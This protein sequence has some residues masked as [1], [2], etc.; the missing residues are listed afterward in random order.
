MLPPRPEYIRRNTRSWSP[1]RIICFDAEGVTQR[2]PEGELDTYR[3]AVVSFDVRGKG[4]TAART[5]WGSF[6]AP[7]AS[8]RDLW[9]W[10]STRCHVGRAT[11]AFAHGTHYDYSVTGAERWLPELG[12][13]RI[14]WSDTYGARWVRWR[15]GKRALLIVDTGNYLKGWQIKDLG[16]LVGLVK[17]GMPRAQA[18]RAAWERYCRRDVEI[19]REVVLRLLEWWDEQDLG[20][21]GF[22]AP[23][24]AK[25]A[26]RHRFMAE[27]SIKCGLP[28]FRALEREAL[29]GGRREIYRKGRLVSAAWADLDYVSH[30]MVTAWETP[31][32]VEPGAVYA[33]ADVADG[34]LERLPPNLGVIARVEVDMRE[35]AVPYRHPRLGICYP[36]GRFVT[37]L[38]QP[39]LE[40]VAAHGR[41][42]RWLEVA[43]YGLAPALESWAEWV[44]AGLEGT[45]RNQLARILLKDWTRSLIG[46]FGQRKPDPQPEVP[47][48][49]P[50]V[51]PEL[52]VTE[53]MVSHDLPWT[54]SPPPDPLRGEDSMNTAPAITAWVHSAARATLWRAMCAVGRDTIAS[55]DTDGMLV[56]VEERNVEAIA[57]LAP[58]VDATKPSPR[59]ALP[60][61][62]RARLRPT[63]KER[64]RAS[65]HKIR[66]VPPPRVP[67]GRM[68]VDDVHGEVT[69]HRPQDYVLDGR[70]V[71]KGLPSDRVTLGPRH[72]RATYWPGIRT[73]IQRAKPGTYLRPIVEVRLGEDYDRAWVAADGRCLPLETEV[74]GGRTRIRAWTR[75]TYA[76]AGVELQDPEQAS[77][78]AAK[79]RSPGS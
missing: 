8:G 47:E 77:R 73:Q 70:E 63:H 39:E 72:Y 76:G 55:V 9:R 11:Y 19:V 16:P 50:V 65:P 6:W 52:T 68:R 4:R 78:V 79:A 27:R 32:P 13:E 54:E 29:F 30:Y 38:C 44:W 31:V 34:L 46:K 41:I 5:E 51:L 33:G 14:S 23:A 10:V 69:L 43:A 60:E 67:P 20:E 53:D 56:R 71:I 64:R 18:R 3:G 58:E 25:A 17:L 7:E 28:E 21:W 37:T 66:E 12:W 15:R 36:V 26:F 75:T 2:V 22:T 45:E 48:E 35:P 42:V 40:L 59:A 49:G 74:R 24:L 57:S 1:D 62:D 61:P